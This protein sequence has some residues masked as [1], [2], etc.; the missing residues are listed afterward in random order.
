M[1]QGVSAQQFHNKKHLNSDY[2][3]IKNTV[4]KFNSVN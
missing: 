4:V 3:I 2:V 1:G